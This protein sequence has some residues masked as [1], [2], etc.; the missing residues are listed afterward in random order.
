MMVWR[1]C[2]YLP[3]PCYRPWPVLQEREKNA[4]FQPSG[5]SKEVFPWKDDRKPGLHILN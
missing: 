5:S 1:D 2:P 4:V 3:L